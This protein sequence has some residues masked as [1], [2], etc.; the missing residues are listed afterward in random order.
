[1]IMKK[2]IVR[3]KE[4]EEGRKDEGKRIIKFKG[5]EE[6]KKGSEI[7]IALLQL[8]NKHITTVTEI[9]ENWHSELFLCKYHLHE[10]H[11]C[12]CLNDTVK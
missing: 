7:L 3:S 6:G 12:D 4:E 1:M 11:L 9:D 2:E 8:I 10:L 5:T